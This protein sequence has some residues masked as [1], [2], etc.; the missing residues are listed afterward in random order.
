M[1][2]NIF[3][4][5]QTHYSNLVHSFSE[6]YSPRFNMHI[7]N[8]NICVL[9]S[10]IKGVIFWNRQIFTQIPLRQLQNIPYSILEWKNP[11]MLI[12]WRRLVLR[13]KIAANI[14]KPRFSCYFCRSLVNFKNLILFWN[15]W[16]IYGFWQSWRNIMFDSEP[17]YKRW[18]I[19]RDF[20]TQNSMS[21]CLLLKLFS[22]I[23]SLFH[24]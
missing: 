5:F 2:T 11:R 1:E 21:V 3:M 13:V 6:Y 24:A 16:V 4:L 12:L 10:C 17:I 8:Y 20:E 22:K 23:Y 18:F 9:W 15:I 14:S 7:F 19:I